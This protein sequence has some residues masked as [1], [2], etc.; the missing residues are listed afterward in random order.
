MVRIDC[1]FCR[2]RT[3]RAS[4]LESL[5]RHA[6]NRSVSITLR[7]RFPYPYTIEAGRAWLDAAATQAPPENLAID[8]AGLAV[9]GIGVIVGSDVHAHTGE[10]GYWL[11]EDYWGR[12]IS[13][14]AVTAFAPWAFRT[15]H[16]TR[17]FADVFS[18]N[19]ASM[20]VLEKA[21][22]VREGLLRQH[23]YKG[24]RYLDMVVYARLDE[25]ESPTV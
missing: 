23:V 24:G 9:G 21:G 2:L 19:P 8:V 10:I 25:P 16:L 4:D 20:R 1:G 22:F 11:G 12:G 15:F 13:T 5:V 18:S 14:A 17:L 6:N 7:D 3:W